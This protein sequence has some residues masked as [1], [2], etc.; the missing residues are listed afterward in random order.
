VIRPADAE[1]LKSEMRVLA[2]VRWPAFG[3]RGRV[4][5]QCSCLQVLHEVLRSSNLLPLEM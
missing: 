4:S 1:L 3:V 2:Y 5:V